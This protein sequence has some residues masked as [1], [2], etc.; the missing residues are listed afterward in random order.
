MARRQLLTREA[1]A[2]HYDPP[3]DEREIARHFTLSREDLDL[4]GERRGASSRLGFA[5][6]LLYMRWPGRVLEAGEKPPG[7]ILAFVAD[8]IEVQATA[9][10]DYARRD[11]TRRAHLADLMQRFS[12]TAFDRNHFRAIV[13]FAMPVAQAVAQPL[14]LAGIVIDELRRRRVLLPPPAVIEAIVRHARQQAE[15]LTHEILINGIE[16]DKLAALDALLTRRSDQGTTWLAW[17]RNAPQ[18]PAARNILRLLERLDHVRTLGLD[19]ARAAMIPSATFDRIADE[20]VRITPQHLGELSPLRRH[21]TLAAAAIRLEESL[22]DAALT[23]FDKLIGSM[24]RRAENRTRDKAIRTVRE[25]QGHLRTLTDSCSTRT[26]RVS[27]PLHVSA[28]STGSGSAP[29][30]P[31]RKS[32]SAPR[33]STAQP[34]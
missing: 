6:L 19:P 8:Q 10:D 33:Q 21:A 11:E 29:L 16:P 18:S 9:S 30:S 4:V 1:L 22:T 17:L 24:T 26:P 13:A 3:T 27:T 34:N 5:M 28:R 2:P 7:A 32:S 15:Q 12:Y 14:L 31:R 23:M 20:A 25:M